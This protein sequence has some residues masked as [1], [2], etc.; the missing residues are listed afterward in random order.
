MAC[1]R[2]HMAE[3]N[4][5]QETTEIVGPL[6]L[7]PQKVFQ[8]LPERCLSA[9]C[10]RLPLSRYNQIPFRFRPSSV[11]YQLLPFGPL[12]ALSTR[13]KCSDFS[14]P[15]FVRFGCHVLPVPNLRS[16]GG[17]EGMPEIRE[18]V[19]RGSMIDTRCPPVGTPL[20]G[21]YLAQNP[22][23]ARSA[24]R[25]DCLEAVRD[26]SIEGLPVTSEGS[27]ILA[28]QPMGGAHLFGLGALALLRRPL[29]CDPSLSITFPQ[30]PITQP[31][32]L[33][34]PID[35]LI[36]LDFFITTLRNHSRF[37]V[38]NDLS[39]DHSPVLLTASLDPTLQ[40][41]INLRVPLKTPEDLDEAVQEFT[42]AV[43]GP[44]GTP[45]RPELLSLT[46]IPSISHNIYVS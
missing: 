2:R 29:Y 39:S 31:T 38:R 12:L 8:F 28:L 35:F 16:A 22:L 40:S 14:S 20:A 41:V 27:E 19:T 30:N 1:K 34:I 3:K 25:G 32:G 4:T 46:R 37:Q 5:K 9:A 17:S 15:S 36:V 18:A 45:H 44:L 21:D 13:D 23:E 10:L 24:V 7:S 43:H 6:F 33:F 11:S 26:W 42:H